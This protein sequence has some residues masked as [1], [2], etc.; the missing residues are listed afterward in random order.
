M[1]IPEYTRYIIRI[2]ASKGHIAYLAGGCVRD[3]L[4]GVEPHDYDIATNATPEQVQSYFEKTVSVGAAFGV[5]IVQVDGNSCEVATFRDDGLYVDGRRPES[6]EYSNPE[7]DAQRRDF[8][9]NALFYDVIT[10]K[11]IDYV[12]GEKDL[13]DRI[14]KAVGDPN[15]RFEEDLLRVLRAIRFSVRFDLAIEDKTKYAMFFAASKLYRLSAERIRDELTKMF[16][17][18]N[19][20]AAF[21]LLHYYAIFRYLLPEIEKLWGVKQPKQWHPEGDVFIHTKLCLEKLEAPY[22]QD[23]ACVWAAVLHDIGKPDAYDVNR[24][25]GASHAGGHDRIG[26]ALAKDILERYKFSNQII[27]EVCYIISEHMTFSNVKE[28]KKSKLRTFL[29]HPQINKLLAVHKADCLAS[30]ADLSAHFCCVNKI[31]EW[32]KET[33]LPPPLINGLDLMGL[34]MTPGPRFGKILNH[35]REMQLSDEIKTK[36]E[37]LEAVLH[38]PRAQFNN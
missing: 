13:K 35:I 11:V 7:K 21:E 25:A 4:L 14:L 3:M 29:G 10:E 12:G 28:M 20:G 22:N 8:T 24:A 9:I 17:G 38:L 2:L 26:A 1:N 19:P 33:I 30:H 6:V 16:M 32:G 34:G 23:V 5:I 15:K 36:K 18:S 31:E 37:A 27:E